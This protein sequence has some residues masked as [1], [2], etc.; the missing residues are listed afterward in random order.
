[1]REYTLP[2][3][4]SLIAYAYPKSK[5]VSQCTGELIEKNVTAIV[6]SN[7][8][9]AL[10]TLRFLNIHHLQVGAD[11]ELLGFSGSDWYGYRTEKIAQVSQPTEEMARMAGQQLLEQIE[12][13]RPQ[14][15]TTVLH[16]TYIPKKQ[17]KEF[18]HV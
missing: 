18:S 16:S 10:E 1:M 9:I 15:R 17:E 13:P 7:N 5:T 14:A 4:D 8:A 12:N 2:I 3:C 11:V 6:V